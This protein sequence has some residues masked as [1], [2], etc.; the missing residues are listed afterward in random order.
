MTTSRWATAAGVTGLAANA[1]LVAFYALEVGRVPPLP[2]SLGTLNDVV[3]AAGTAMMI[4][5]AMALCGRR[6]RALGVTAAVVLTSAG[7]L[8]VGGVLPFSV[9]LPITLTAFLGLAAWILLVSGPDLGGPVRRLGLLCGGAAL[10]G[11]AVAGLGALLPAMSW[12]QLALFGIGGVP[13]VLA[14]L[15]MPLWFLRLGRALRST[16]PHHA[17]AGESGR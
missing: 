3:G 16:T 4:P 9:Q 6:V 10:A 15:A 13:A 12:P 14:V 11:A 17:E 5:V 7:L 2:V 1:L 8:L